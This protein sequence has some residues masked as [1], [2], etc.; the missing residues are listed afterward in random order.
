MCFSNR[1]LL[2]SDVRIESARFVRSG[3]ISECHAV[4]HATDADAPYAKQLGDIHAAYFY[5]LSHFGG[6]LHPVFRRYFLSDAANQQALLQQSGNPYPPCAVSCVEQ[7]PLDG[8]K[9]A[10]WVYLQSGV[11]V[12]PIDGGVVAAHN[13]YGHIWTGG[14]AVADGD[15]AGQTEALLE[16]YADSLAP[17]GCTLE[18][19]C[20]RTWFFVQNVDVNYAGVVQGRRELFERHGLTPQTHYI[21]STGIEGRC[22]DPRCSVLLDAYAVRGLRRGQQT[23]LHAPDHLNPTYEYGVTFERGVRV[24]YGDR[25][26]VLLSGTASI[27]NRGEIVAPGDIAAQT[28]RMLENVG[29]LLSEAGTSPEDLAQMIV[30]LRDG[31]D[32]P[33]VRS[34]MDERFGSVPKVLVRAPVCRPGWLIETECIAVRE[35]ENPQFAPL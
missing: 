31:A 10:L 33:V 8:S 27:D 13:G 5:L 30:Y 35:E 11:E 21:T 23:Y 6:E 22:A 18:G 3:G 19:D 1:T 4:L 25:C 20:V 28:E 9:I 14:A 29:A 12:S 15:S 32:Y 16:R 7:P 26:H 24:A 2:F 34:I 17:L